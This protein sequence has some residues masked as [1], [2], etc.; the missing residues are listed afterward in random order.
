MSDDKEI[1][2]VSALV[3]IAKD[4][5]Y[6]F[7]TVGEVALI[8]NLSKDTMTDLLR[9]GAP[10]VARKMN[11]NVFQEWLKTGHLEVRQEK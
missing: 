6:R 11:P 8:F 4:N 3:A 2:D 5:P 10:T 1:E 9:I 7:F